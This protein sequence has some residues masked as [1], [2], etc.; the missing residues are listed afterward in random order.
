[1]S[2]GN[3]GTPPVEGEAPQPSAPQAPE[4]GTPPQQDEVTTLRSRNAGLDAKVTELQRKAA[5]AERKAQEAAAK[6]SDYESGK[7]Q[8][9]EAL[10]AQLSEKD[11][12]LAEVRRQMALTHV[13]SKYPETF[14]V[15]GDAAAHLTEDQLAA[16]EAR[17][18][19]VG[20]PETPVP[21]GA[22]PARNPAAATKAIEDMNAD[23]LRQHMRR[24]GNEAASAWL[25]GD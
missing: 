2:D 17:M 16:S 22:N 21:V 14:G 6:L 18:R 13:A 11:A 23:E 25:H 12:E 3:A 9:D 15:L 8:A 10:R 7:V 20:M 4:A 19:G 1:M 5:E 24:L